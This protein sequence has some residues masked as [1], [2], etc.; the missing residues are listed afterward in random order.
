MKYIQYPHINQR[1]QCNCDVY[2]TILVDESKTKGDGGGGGVGK[3]Y[4]GTIPS[5]GEKCI[6]YILSGICS[7]CD[8]SIYKTAHGYN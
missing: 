6:R 4:P 1:K 8:P 7:E 5:M 3:R 2:C